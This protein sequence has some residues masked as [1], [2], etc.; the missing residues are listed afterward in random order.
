MASERRVSTGEACQDCVTDHALDARFG[1]GEGSQVCRSCNVPRP[2]EP[3]CLRHAV[4]HETREEPIEGPLP[5]FIVNRPLRFVPPGLCGREPVVDSADP[6]TFCEEREL[7]LRVLAELN[8]L[9]HCAD[10]ICLAQKLVR[11][12]L[13]RPNSD[14]E[15]DAAENSARHQFSTQEALHPSRSRSRMTFVFSGFRSAPTLTL[16]TSGSCRKGNTRIG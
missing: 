16:A 8:A 4:L 6:Q 13:P 14:S 10:D 7:C 5:N 15:R 9:V 11:D 12:E 3:G 1:C 2:F